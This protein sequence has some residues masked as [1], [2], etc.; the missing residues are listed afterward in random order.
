MKGLKSSRVQT[1][2]SKSVEFA[3]DFEMSSGFGSKSS[4]SESEEELVGPVP[5][6]VY[7]RYLTAT[8]W[9]PLAMLFALLFLAVQGKQH[10]D[11]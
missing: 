6:W 7:W 10:V 1:N 8:L 11:I 4:F 3:E 9:P 2:G 5:S